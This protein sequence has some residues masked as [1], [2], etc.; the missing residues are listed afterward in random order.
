V[1]RIKRLGLGIEF[2]EA[3]WVIELKRLIWGIE[4]K[5]T[6]GWGFKI[7]VVVLGC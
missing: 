7:K 3:G 2:K 5:E 6:K 4:V 1:G